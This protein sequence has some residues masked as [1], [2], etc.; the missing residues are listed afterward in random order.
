MG[1]LSANH[2]LLQTPEM[3]LIIQNATSQNTVGRCLILDIQCQK[4]LSTVKMRND[5]AKFAIPQTQN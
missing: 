2:K 5:S 3:V 4:I 1:N